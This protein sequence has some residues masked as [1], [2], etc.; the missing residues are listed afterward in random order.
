MTILQ[1]S[2]VIADGSN[3]V[4]SD[5]LGNIEPPGMGGFFAA[6]TRFL[7]RLKV[8]LQGHPGLE[9]GAEQVDH[10]AASFYATLPG[11][12]TRQPNSISLVRD[13]YIAGGMH[14][15][16]SV[17]NHTRRRMRLTL[18]IQVD[19]DFADLFEVREGAFT[20]SGSTSIQKRGGVDI[21][22]SY[23]SGD[24]ER[25]THISF[26]RHPKLRQGNALFELELGPK[27]KWT[28]CL[29]V[30]PVID[31]PTDTP[32]CLQASLGSPFGPYEPAMRAPDQK[33]PSR[34][35]EGL[36]HAPELDGGE[37]GL[38]QAFAAAISD[39]HSLT[40]E[41][42]PGV[43]ILAAGLPWFMAVFGRDAIISALQTKI[44][45]PRLMLGTLSSL[46]DLQATEVDEFRDAAPGKIPHEIRMGELSALDAVPHSRYYGTVDATP[47]FVRL[48]WEAYQWTGDR[49]LLE[50]RLAAAEA[51]IAWIDR[52]GDSDG[53]GF[54]EYETTSPRGLRNQGWKDST[55][56]ISFA[57]GR[58]AKGPIALAEVQGYVYN[59]KRCMAE[60]Y[61]AL[62]RPDDGERLDRQ[63]CELKR[64]FNEA[65]WMS[66]EGCFALALD[67][68]KRQVDSITSN[69]GQ[70]LWT[71]IVDE[72]KAGALVARMMAP[73]MFNGWGVR[74][75]SSEMARYNPLSYHNGSIWPHDNSLIASGMQRYGYRAE[76]LRIASAILEAAEGLPKNR[77]PE[78]FAGFPRRWERAPVPYPLANA[79][80]AWASGAVIYLVETIM[81]LSVVGDRIQTGG[82]PG[83]GRRLHL[84]GVSFRGMLLNL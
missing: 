26:S 12:R 13:R 52:Y 83:T 2:I 8:L 50:E 72:E 56:S 43:R 63:A 65:F 36:L 4:V 39:L 51:A 53:D 37:A 71:G 18:T 20:K 10:A 16:L 21:C 61:R 59:A 7:S 78:L 76:A 60:I 19:A 22:F 25:E 27:E 57:D 35:H 48:L 74:T 1:N 75:M 62:G 28:T 30:L 81:G 68:K 41:Y 38:G 46:A 29:T 84:R 80:Q 55:D 49:A 5:R 17:V 33:P 58:L 82:E 6:D 69:A 77:L 42:A 40:M 15:D 32:R 45:G 11:S 3:F 79:P 31:A 54:V 66:G 23:K 47:L 14:E 24:F 9:V 64:M 70:C 34:L 44:L 73:D 67:G